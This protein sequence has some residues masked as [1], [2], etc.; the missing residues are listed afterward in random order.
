MMRAL[1]WACLT[2][3]FF[4]STAIAADESPQAFVQRFY[5]LYRPMD[6]YV[7]AMKSPGT[8]ALLDPD[9]VTALRRE[10]AEAKEAEG[11]DSDPFCACQDSWDSYIAGPALPVAGGYRVTV[12]GTGNSKP[13]PYAF[14]TVDVTMR[15]GHWLMT[16]FRYPDGRDLRTDLR[17][18]RQERREAA[19]AEARKRKNP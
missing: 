16:N 3:A 13:R 17:R 12:S 1:V 8:R 15:G 10:R 14:L 2:V 19:M 7:Q 18:Y 4:A 9:L 11:L 5:D 6:S